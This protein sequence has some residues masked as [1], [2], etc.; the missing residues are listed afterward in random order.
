MTHRFKARRLATGKHFRR[1]P[2]ALLAVIVLA[3]MLPLGVVTGLIYAA[4]RPLAT[5][6]KSRTAARWVR[7]P[8]A[9]IA[10]DQTEAGVCDPTTIYSPRNMKES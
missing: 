4:A 10:Q 2:R 6:P 1:P 8:T 7:R 5:E 9:Q 3:A